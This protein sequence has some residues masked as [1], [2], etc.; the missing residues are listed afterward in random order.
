MIGKGKPSF[1]MSGARPMDASGFPEWNPRHVPSDFLY[2]ERKRRQ[3][4]GC[5][6]EQKANVD[7]QRELQA[8]D[9]A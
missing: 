3:E 1:A 9:Y 5:A 7:H 4:S 6:R 2:A 8:K